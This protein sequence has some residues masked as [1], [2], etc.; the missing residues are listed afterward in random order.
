M[1]YNTI[2]VQYHQT[3]PACLMV[4]SDGGIPHI[5]NKIFIDYGPAR[6]DNQSDIHQVV[7]PQNEGTLDIDTTWNVFCF[8]GM[9]FNCTQLG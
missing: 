1:T 5:K 3:L 8:L 2:P 9:W 4:W 7:H 6:S